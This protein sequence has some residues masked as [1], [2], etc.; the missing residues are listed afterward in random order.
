MFPYYFQGRDKNSPL[1]RPYYVTDIGW[2]EAHGSPILSVLLAKFC[3]S[4]YSANEGTKAER[5]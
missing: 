5:S 4:P 3:S 1:N 2:L